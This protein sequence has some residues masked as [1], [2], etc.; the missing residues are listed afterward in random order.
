[1][2]T[3]GGVEVQLYAFLTS[4]LDGRVWLASPPGRFIP[5]D[6]VPVMQFVWCLGGPRRESNPGR[7]ARSQASILTWAI[8]A[9]AYCQW[10]S[11]RDTPADGSGPAFM[12]FESR[13]G[14]SSVYFRRTM[15]T[16]W[17]IGVLGF[18]SWQ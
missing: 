13:C 16:G 17:T 9:I 15:A 3:Y 7:L 4:A 18:D 6:R 8:P 12:Q 1:M 10:D 2:K 11:I 5:E 14:D